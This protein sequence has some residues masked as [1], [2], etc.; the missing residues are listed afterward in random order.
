MK[1]ITGLLFIAAL[2]VGLLS[3]CTTAP[4]TKVQ[5]YIKG[6]GDQLFI[7]LRDRNYVGEIYSRS[8]NINSIGCVYLDVEKGY[9]RLDFGI[10][11]E[12]GR[13]HHESF[14]IDL[15]QTFIEWLKKHTLYAE[16]QAQ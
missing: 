9:I 13:S 7:E 6:T 11:G 1:R 10:A 5:D 16:Q 14:L 3:S 4:V 12:G 15:N 2:A 8:Y